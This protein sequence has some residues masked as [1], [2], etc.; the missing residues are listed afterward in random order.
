MDD[1]VASAVAHW[2]PRFTVNGVTVAD[3]ERV[4]GGVER[5]EDW[6]AAWVAVAGEHEEL[7]REALAQGRTR[8]AGEHLAQA[9]VYYHFAKFVFV[10]DLEQMRSAHARAVACLDDALPHLEP[11][12]RRIEM[13]FEGTRLVGV[14]RL[15]AGGGPHPVVVMLS[16]LDSAKEELRSTEDTFLARG[17]ATFAIDGPGQGEAEYDLPIRGDWSAVTEAIWA[18]LGELPEVD[19]SRLGLWGV[20]LGGYYAPRVASALGDRAA[21]CVGLAGPFNFGECWDGLP[22][23]TRATFQVRS[24]ASDDDEA[25]A[26]ALTL[27]LQDVAA[28][29]T[30]P[31]LLVFGRKDRL[32]PWQQADKVRAAVAGPVEL[33][34]LENGNHGCANVAPWHR[35]RT[36]DWLAGHLLGGGPPDLSPSSSISK[37][38]HDCLHR[39]LPS[40]DRRHLLGPPGRLDRNRPHGRRDGRTPGQGRHRHDGVEPHQGQGRTPGRPGVRR[41]GLDRQLR[42]LDVVFTMVSTPADLEQVLLGEGGLIADPDHVPRRV[43]DCSTVSMESSAAMRAA[44][45]VRGVDFLSAPVSGNG[46]VVRSGGLTLAVSGPHET[47]E[48]FAPLLDHIGKSVT[49][50][51]E[52]D[53]A[54]LV[55]ICHNLMLGRRHAEPG[56]DHRAGREGRR[57]RVA[58]SWS[59]STTP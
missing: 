26:I 36:A 56:R 58:S 52:G 34:M 15:P 32:I 29:I 35:P 12:G 5:W 10:V 49:Y 3:F 8:S 13:P 54:R 22:A 46:K 28:D 1:L 2:G 55:K 16:G 51:G 53:L 19:R 40:S 39:R 33:L 27:G 44:C 7:G 41:G 31:L 57:T 9:A 37:G 45:A 48:R 30:C 11:P 17:L 24:G 20:S 25:R 14:L 21:A 18:K 47:Y 4:T 23:L 59:S 6:C 38:A 42:D 50:V 43:V